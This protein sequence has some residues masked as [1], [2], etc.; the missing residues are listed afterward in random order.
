MAARPPT[1]PTSDDVYQ[2]VSL[3][4]DPTFYRSIY[5]ELVGTDAFQHYLHVGWRE[6][7]DPAPWFSTTAYLAAN[8]DVRRA[9][10]EP[11]SHYLIRGAAEGRE[12]APS[13]AANAYYAQTAGWMGGWSFE[14]VSAADRAAAADPENATRLAQ[15]R[16]VVGAEFDAEFY[17]KA[18]LDIASAG[19]DPLE[20]FLS[21]GWR[22]GRDPTP[23]FSVDD[24][25]EANPD[26]GATDR[27]PFVH[28]VRQGRAEGRLIHHELGFRYDVIARLVPPV[29]RL[30]ASIEGSRKLASGKAAQLIGRL[31]TAP[32]RLRRLHVTFSHDDYTAVVGGVQL[33]IRREA[34]RFAERGVDHLHLYP[35]APWSFVREG[36]E[37]GPLGVLLN[38]EPLGVY[39]PKVV[40]DALAASPPGVR[41]SF[42]I[43]SLLG[44]SASD[45]IAILG[46][47]GLKAGYLW[48]HDFASLCAGVHLLRNDVEDCAAPR[49]DSAAC[50]VCAYGTL[51]ARHIAAHR[52]LFA[53]LE[54]TVVAPS[55]ATLDFWRD[56]A[57]PLARA[58]VVV[59]HA[60]LV[61]RAPARRK[62]G[63]L[64]VAFLGMPT[65]LKGWPIFRE[66]A[67]RFADDPRYQFLHL[68]GR[69]DARVPAAF[70]EVAATSAQPDAMRRAIERHGVDVAL[71]WPLCR[72]TFSFTAYE[73]VAGGAAVVTGPDSGNVA[74]FV[75]DTGF[76]RVLSSEACLTTAFESGELLA[77][78]RG[79]RRLFDLAYSA[80]TAELV[81]P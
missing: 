23:W 22:E 80:M 44:H 68:G 43:H 50:Q 27:N 34:A 16:A 29:E 19:V 70:H 38:G 76:G 47:L 49:P 7:R 77:L 61:E 33:C 1:A 42:A 74:A 36:R 17:L 40:R 71:V 78:G 8:D 69:P 2:A 79:R 26:V 28:Y 64:R 14:A 13:I 25:L 73:A 32:T 56:A 3:A 57:R 4:V 41:R 12:V 52:R 48:L 30:A 51:R 45:T 53:D 75:G 15:D 35:A 21:T 39:S 63:P 46:A 24:Y 5:P 54:L 18:N 65:A 31:A 60:T 59:P 62:A 55:Q 37:L 66:L 72:E 58:V 11:L 9:G 10:V 81:Q 6:G 67:L 20:H